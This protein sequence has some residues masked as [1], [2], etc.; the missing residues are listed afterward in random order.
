MRMGWVVLTALMAA[1]A[2]CAEA[3]PAPQPTH[4]V[5][6]GWVFD[7]AL[8][9]IAGATVRIDDNATTTA[10]DGSYRIGGILPGQI[11]VI[12]EAPGHEPDSRI[13][14]I[15]VAG[16][17]RMVNLTLDRIPAIVPTVETSRYA[18]VIACNILVEVGHDH[19]SDP[20]NHNDR[21][22]TVEDIG[23]DNVWRIPVRQGVAGVVVEVF[24]EPG[25]MLAE[26]LVGFFEAIVPDGDDALVDFRE[27]TSGF[28]L[29]LVPSQAQAYFPDGGDL[30]LTLAAGAA[31]GDA[32]TSVHINQEFEAIAS[33]FYHKPPPIDFT[34]MEAT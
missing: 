9:P 23:Q 29:R 14:S 10:P 34:V 13:A 30:R 12:A 18:G 24:W 20:H 15:E 11:L 6:T 4:S 22:C 19:G 27:G 26:N 8:R 7:D 17:E 3:P 31:E 1:C 5:V 25:T 2:G 32:S 16:V 33:I 28:Q 21:D